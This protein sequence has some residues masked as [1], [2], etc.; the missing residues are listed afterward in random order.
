MSET[1]EKDRVQIEETDLVF[2]N[3]NKK[4]Y[5]GLEYTGP[6]SAKTNISLESRALVTEQQLNYLAKDVRDY[7]DGQNYVAYYKQ[8]PNL[9]EQITAVDNIF[10]DGVITSKIDQVLNDKI[11]KAK[12][13]STF[14][15]NDLGIE[16]ILAGNKKII[17]LTPEAKKGQFG[18]PILSEFFSDVSNSEIIYR[19]NTYEKLIDENWDSTDIVNG[20]TTNHVAGTYEQ[21]LNDGISSDGHLDKDKARTKNKYRFAEFARYDNECM[22]GLYSYHKGGSVPAF[23]EYLPLDWVTFIPKIFE[24]LKAGDILYQPSTGDVFE[25]I[26]SQDFVTCNNLVGLRPLQDGDGNFTNL[27]GY[28]SIY[29]GE[30]KGKVDNEIFRYNTFKN[31]FSAKTGL[32]S[33]KA[34]TGQTVTDLYLKAFNNY[35]HGDMTEKTADEQENLEI[36]HFIKTNNNINSEK[37]FPTIT[38]QNR[39]RHPTKSKGISKVTGFNKTN[40]SLPKYFPGSQSLDEWLADDNSNVYYPVVNNNVARLFYTTASLD[41]ESFGEDIVKQYPRGAFAIHCKKIGNLNS[42]TIWKYTDDILFGNGEEYPDPTNK[43]DVEIY[44]KILSSV[45]SKSSTI[46]KKGD[47]IYNP[48]STELRRIVRDLCVSETG[49]GRKT[50]LTEPVYTQIKSEQDGIYIEEDEELKT[51]IINRYC[52]TYLRGPGT[53]FMSQ[54][55]EE[56]IP[57]ISVTD[58]IDS[59]INLYDPSKGN[60]DGKNLPQVGNR[61]YNQAR[62][63]KNKLLNLNKAFILNEDQNNT[64]TIF[65]SLFLQSKQSLEYYFSDWENLENHARFAQL[66]TIIPGDQIIA[67]IEENDSINYKLYQVTKN[68]Y[69]FDILK[70]EDEEGLDTFNYKKLYV[71]FVAYRKNNEGEVTLHRAFLCNSLI[72]E[73]ERNKSSENRNKYF[74]YVIP[75]NSNTQKYVY[76]LT[77]IAKNI[78]F[79][80]DISVWI[81]KSK[82]LVSS[83]INYDFSKVIEFARD[84]EI[85]Y[86]NNLQQRL[87]NNYQAPI[88]VNAIYLTTIPNTVIIKLGDEE[89]IDQI[90]ELGLQIADNSI[91][92]Y[93]LVTELQDKI[94]N[95]NIFVTQDGYI[96]SHSSSTGYDYFINAFSNYSVAVSPKPNDIIINGTAVYKVVGLDFHPYAQK[97][98]DFNSQIVTFDQLD[99][100]IQ[101]AI[102]TAYHKPTNGIPLNDLELNI[103]TKLES[104]RIYDA[105]SLPDYETLTYNENSDSYIF[106]TSNAE[107]SLRRYSQG[108]YIVK[109][110]NLLKFEF[111]FSTQTPVTAM[112]SNLL[113]NNFK[114]QYAG[115]ESIGAGYFSYNCTTS[116]QRVQ[117]FQKALECIKNNQNI[118]ISF[119]K[120]PEIPSPI[121]NL[122]LEGGFITTMVGEN[123]FKN[124]S[125]IIPFYFSG[126]IYNYIWVYMENG[127]VDTPYVIIN[128]VI[129]N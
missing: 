78:E 95:F 28:W 8:N 38:M 101:N 73:I 16:D 7:L 125:I 107:E 121:E 42:N 30:I 45:L 119:V 23:A 92:E 62:A 19:K 54:S 59:M 2:E 40:M 18:I 12:G 29:D 72:T 75:K 58:F 71:N 33:S 3:N 69:L 124:T 82:Q 53:K 104:G 34:I 86:F 43:G 4:L 31:E 83:G 44:Q 21:K 105:Q 76:D 27:Y 74:Y 126:Q 25:V 112:K 24:D 67:Q 6:D 22:D 90:S 99:N 128:P 100:N 89:I 70:D 96:P 48:N 111:M 14:T 41:P 68:P 129:S 65:N 17:I 102:S 55:F 108:D 115:A 37:Y 49:G 46:P 85:E 13:I 88:V 5:R 51:K 32:R 116:A 117:E 94:N 91:M 81:E 10:G 9:T 15:V 56:E 103:R 113:N 77:N 11:D 35:I 87:L 97:I 110:P 122:T 61:Y 60:L 118:K 1:K 26:N 20:N 114:F 93:K 127:G 50:Y 79:T 106:T 66:N 57:D 123:N 64:K 84:N 109:G 47:Y 39:Y 80:E 52:G 63:W 98:G 36:A 120:N